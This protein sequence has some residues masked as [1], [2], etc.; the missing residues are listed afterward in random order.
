VP[1]LVDYIA[2][3]DRPSVLIEGPTQQGVESIVEMTT[4]SGVM[5]DGSGDP[6][7]W[8]LLLRR[9]RAMARTTT[10]IVSIGVSS[11]SWCALWWYRRH[12]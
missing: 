9:L 7:F 3:L 2:V 12:L 6:S 8:L 5:S 10:V 11:S 1:M 4:A